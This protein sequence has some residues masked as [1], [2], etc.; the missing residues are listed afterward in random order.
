MSK[1]NTT[2]G[3]RLKRYHKR[4]VHGEI[5]VEE[6]SKKDM[7]KTPFQDLPKEEPYGIIFLMEVMKIKGWKQEK[8]RGGRKL[9]THSWH[10]EIF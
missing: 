9:E 6:K 5:R 2:E 8:R 1:E 10:K 7:V 3:K 4:K